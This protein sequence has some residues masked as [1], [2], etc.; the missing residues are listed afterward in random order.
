MKKFLLWVFII[1]I[2][3]ITLKIFVLTPLGWKYS[4]ASP[5]GQKN[6]HFAT[7]PT[8][9]PTPNSPRTFQFDSSTDLKLELDKV[10]PQMLDSDFE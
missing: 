3:L 2:S 8:P 9:V 5:M 10:N 6:Y 1:F 4:L 7:T